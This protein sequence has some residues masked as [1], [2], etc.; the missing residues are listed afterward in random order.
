MTDLITTDAT[1]NAENTEIITLLLGLMIPQQGDMPSASDSAIVKKCLEGLTSSKSL[2]VDAVR[3][4]KDQTDSFAGL[5]ESQQAKLI[6]R[7]KSEK[8]D[9]IAEFQFNAAASYYSDTRVLTVLGLEGRA[10]HPGGYV[11]P[12]T[13]WGLLAPVT[14]RGSIYRRV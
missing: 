6:E 11:A 4:I 10:P 3:F 5:D 12:E 1:F 8:A 2:V 13:D 7:L 9:F 14:E